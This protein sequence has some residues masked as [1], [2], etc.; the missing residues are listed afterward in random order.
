M[1]LSVKNN[2]TNEGKGD[3]HF[4]LFR[5]AHSIL[6]RRATVD[7]E[8]DTADYLICESAL[9]PVVYNNNNNYSYRNE[10][11]QSLA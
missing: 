10:I 6:Q 3:L 4:S 7:D 1:Q 11:A 2:G 9:T 5:G 8:P